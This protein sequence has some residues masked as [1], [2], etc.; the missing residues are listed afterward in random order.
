MKKEITIKVG[1]NENGII[2]MVGFAGIDQ[3]K[4]EDRLFLI[5]LLEHLK[6]MEL[7]KIKTKKSLKRTEDG[8]ED[9]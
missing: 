2:S 6:Q 4:I 1:T 7:D 3:T 5:G 9:L 8:W